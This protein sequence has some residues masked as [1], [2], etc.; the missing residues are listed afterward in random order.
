VRRGVLFT[1]ILLC[2]AFVLPGSAMAG[3]GLA[4]SSNPD[5]GVAVSGCTYTANSTGA[6]VYVGEVDTCLEDGTPVSITDPS[7]YGGSI[8]VDTAIDPSSCIDDASLTLDEEGGPID[9]NDAMDLGTCPLSLDATGSITQGAAAITGGALSIPG[10]GSVSLT[11]TGNAIGGLFSA[12]ADGELSFTNSVGVTLGPITDPG[13][14]V[15]I[16]STAGGIDVDDALSSD[17]TVMLT[18]S[19]GTV[20]E[21]GPGSIAAQTLETTSSGSTTL[22]GSSNAVDAFETGD[23]GGTLDLYDQDPVELEG[24]SETAGFVVDDAG[25][26]D[27]AAQLA[28]PGDSGSLVSYGGTVSED[29][30]NVFAASLTVI[31]NA[32]ENS[33]AP[34]SGT[35]SLSATNYVNTLTALAYYGNVTAYL[36]GAT[37]TLDNIKASGGS[38]SVT[39]GDGSLD[40]TGLVSGQSI[41]LD[42]DGVTTASGDDATL[43]APSVSITD[44]DASDEWTVTPSTVAA[45][46]TGTIAYTGASTLSITGGDSFDVTPSSATE[47]ALSAGGSGSLTYQAQGRTVSGATTAPSGQIDSPGVEPVG[48]SGMA[49]VTLNDVETPPT[50]GGSGGGSSGGGTTT[51]TTPSSNPP[52]CTL[53]ASRSKV[54][55]PK[56]VHGKLKGE[57]TLTLVATCSGAVHVILSAGIT[58]VSKPAHGK[59]KTK[60]YP[61]PGVRASIAAGVPTKIVMDVPNEALSALSTNGDK[62]SAMFTLAD[63]DHGDSVLKTTSIKRLT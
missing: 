10:S 27:V 37:A 31:G 30:G 5:G 47:I 34:G 52:T 32:D 55:L 6:N 48:F 57:A 2:A 11:D 35:V 50:S 13:G 56:R 16:D 24:F 46:G 29:E 23:I 17:A 41:A 22:D 62:L 43:A 18:A 4:I 42:A 51:P 25:D 45:E 15:T 8:D 59:K 21:T 63:T 49:S 54:A 9:L 1:L 58:A 53:R 61:I 3:T 33:T 36:W 19:G 7:G 12:T 14:D 44:T 26:I 28:A 60:Y 39:N 40:P 38:V 20:D